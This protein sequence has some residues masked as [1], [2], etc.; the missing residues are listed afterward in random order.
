MA[1]KICVGIRLRPLNQRELDQGANRGDVW[2]VDSKQ[3]SQVTKNGRIVPG[4]TLQFDEVFDQERST[5]EVYA[6]LGKPLIN[7]PNNN[8]DNPNFKL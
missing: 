2:K 1:E 8:P 6:S 4:S 3:I 5:E 7:S